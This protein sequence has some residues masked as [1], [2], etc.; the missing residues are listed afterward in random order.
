MGWELMEGSPELHCYETFSPTNIVGIERPQTACYFDGTTWTSELI[1]APGTSITSIFSFS[2]DNLFVAGG[3]GKI[4]HYDGTTWTEMITPTDITLY[5]IWG[6]SPTDIYAVGDGELPVLHYDGHIWTELSVPDF[7]PWHFVGGRSATD[8]YIGA[9]DGEL[10]HYDGLV[11]SEVARAAGKAVFYV[12]G[13]STDYLYTRAIGSSQIL[14]YDGNSWTEIEGPPG[15]N[16]ISSF[17]F[18]SPLDIYA[19]TRHIDHPYS[20]TQI[21]HYGRH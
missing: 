18:G 11:W 17:W 6:S 4:F 14:I 2:R 16:F 20:T 8:V 3:R 9:M 21:Y 19:F 5:D 1:G 7:R 12:Y 15:R 13:I 10:Y